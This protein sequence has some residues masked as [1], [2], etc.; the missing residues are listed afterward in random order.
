[1]SMDILMDIYGEMDELSEVVAMFEGVLAAN[2]IDMEKDLLVF[3]VKGYAFGLY[4]GEG[5]IPQMGVFID[6]ISSPD[7]AK[8]VMGK[9]FEGIEGFIDEMRE[10]LE[11]IVVHAKADCGTGECYALTFAFDNLPDD[12]KVDMPEEF[13]GEVVEFGYGLNS[14]NLAYFALYPDFGNGGF[15]TMD[16]NERFNGDRKYIAGFDQQVTYFDVEKTV[17]YVDR[18]VQFAIK[19]D[20]GEPGEMEEYEMVKQYLKPVKSLILGS[21]EA[22]GGIVE[23]QGFLKITQ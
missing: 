17:E 15:E 12:A 23:M 4:A 18:W 22:E 2:D 7:G 9:V 20:G 19:V 8:K 1:M 10:E 5:I 11:G 14:D 6:A 13:I 21:K 16:N 3:M